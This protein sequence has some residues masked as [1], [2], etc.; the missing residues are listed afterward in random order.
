MAE[1]EELFVSLE[2][3]MLTLLAYSQ[4]FKK[5]QAD[6]ELTVSWMSKRPTEVDGLDAKKAKIKAQT[7]KRQAEIQKEKALRDE[8]ELQ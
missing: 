8:L 5:L 1:N 2:E 4:K 6:D 7:I 3:N